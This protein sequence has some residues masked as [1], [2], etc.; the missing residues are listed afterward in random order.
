MSKFW[1]KYSALRE[2]YKDS[3]FFRENGEYTKA[4]FNFMYNE[5]YERIKNFFIEYI[6]L[7]P[8]FSNKI[9]DEFFVKFR[10][11]PKKRDLIFRFISQPE[12]GISNQNNQVVIHNNRSIESSEHNFNF[13]G[14]FLLISIC[15]KISSLPVTK[16]LFIANSIRFKAHGGIALTRKL[17]SILFD[18]NRVFTSRTGKHLIPKLESL[19]KALYTLLP[20]D[21]NMASVR[22]STAYKA[23][24]NREQFLEREEFLD[25]IDTFRENDRFRGKGQELYSE[26]INDFNRHNEDDDHEDHNN[27]TSPFVHVFKHITDE[28]NEIGSSNF[29]LNFYEEHLYNTINRSNINKERV[30]GEFACY[31]YGFGGLFDWEDEL[32]QGYKS[33]LL[34]VHELYGVEADSAKYYFSAVAQLSKLQPKLVDELHSKIYY[35]LPNNQENHIN[36]IYE[37]L[38]SL[39]HAQP[40]GNDG[41]QVESWASALFKYAELDIL[42]LFESTLKPKVQL[43]FSLSGCF[44]SQQGLSKLEVVSV[45]SDYLDES[46]V[47]T[48]L[49]DDIE[50]LM[51]RNR[52]INFYVRYKSARIANK[53]KV[54]IFKEYLPDCRVPQYN[55]VR[56]RILSLDNSNEWLEQVEKHLL[57][58]YDIRYFLSRKGVA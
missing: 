18:V 16:D 53:V 13:D 36:C 38:D 32:P 19:I 26:L 51:A 49:K 12:N 30:A 45:F 28:I 41:K 17:E 42:T 37:F 1:D 35:E 5:Y 23:K 9:G 57:S 40:G 52:P 55:Q 50:K 48:F 10:S 24:I 29:W 22:E 47:E 6:Q 7:Y 15:H 21:W 3:P 11:A 8:Y 39:M 44:K 14:V 27:T 20:E 43:F 34:K 4:E 58:I 33:I 56:D 25:A 54:K 2:D 46:E 31:L